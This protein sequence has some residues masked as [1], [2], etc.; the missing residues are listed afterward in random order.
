[1]ANLDFGTTPVFEQTDTKIFGT[2][3]N[4]VQ[5][6]KLF[7]DD[8]S[9]QRALATLQRG[10]VRFYRDNVFVFEDDLDD[11]LLSSSRAWFAVAGPAKTALAMSLPFIFPAICLVGQT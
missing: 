7:A 11:Y 2:A 4:A 9:L 1:M 10:P 3:D 6:E 5:F 8:V